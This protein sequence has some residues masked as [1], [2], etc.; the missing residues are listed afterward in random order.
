M[1]I[2]KSPEELEKMHRAGLIVWGALDKMREM[3]RP[4]LTTKE[5]DDFAEAYAAEHKA[6]PAFKGYRGYPGS[7]CTSINQEVVHGIPSKSRRL[8][9]G[10][11]L[12]LDFGVELDGYFAD[13][14]LTVPVGKVKPEREKLLRVTRESLEH[15]IEKVRPGNRLGDVS[16]AVQTW[17]EKNGYSVVR[18]FVGHGIGTRMHEEPQIPNYGS[19]GQGPR[20]QTGMVLAIEPMVN[21]GGAAVRVLDDDWTAVT[22]D[23]SDSA[24]FEHTVA[25]TSNGPWILTRP[26]EATGPVW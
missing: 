18:E 6:R 14:A 13:A 5:L 11:I 22:A 20:L 9:E 8:K 26:K 24:H 10:D 3:I 7:V 17:V 4:G 19:P 12:S 1:V 25:V 21:T 16:A 15:A 2:C 23:G